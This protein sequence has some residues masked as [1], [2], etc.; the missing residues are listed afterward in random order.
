MMDWTDRHC[1]VF[2]RLMSRRARLYT[3]ML[4]TGA[5][6]H[7]DR[8][9]LLG[10]D[11][12]EHPVALQLG[13]SDPDDLATAARIGEEFGYDEINLNVGCPSDRV[14]DGRFGACLMAEPALVAEGVAAMKR[15]VQIPVTVKCRIGIDDQDPEA[16]LDT[17]ARGVIAAGAD[18]LV[19][20]ARKAWLNGLSPK[21]N[22]DIPPLDYDRV[23]RLKAA[24]PDVP[25]II[26]G[27]ITSL[28]EAR[29]HLARVDGVML[30]RAAYQEP[31]RLLTVDSELFGETPAHATMKDVFEAML[32]YIE[33]QL[34]AGT[35]LHSIT[36]HF[37]GAFHGV[38]GARAF[39]RHLAENGVRPGA[40]IDV[41]RDAIA[42]VDDRAR[43]AVAA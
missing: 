41:L 13:G 40:E 33:R 37:V 10:F 26:N 38:P 28:A 39:R 22:R 30:G 32:P 11:A 35:R 1:R 19:V 5:V 18:V 31:W 14:K 29:Q 20:H 3:E 6:I 21:E 25:I 2:H 43:T 15:A 7:G 42:R 16:A 36:R 34:A 12:I 4:T 24:L 23:Y 9:R 17:L 27:G 8:A